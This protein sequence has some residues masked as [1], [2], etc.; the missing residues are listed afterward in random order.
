MTNA[1]HRLIVC[2]EDDKDD[3]FLFEDTLAQVKKGELYTLVFA[4]N[5]E[6][7][8]QTLENLPRLPDILFLDLNMPRKDGFE[9][10]RQLRAS[11]RYDQ[12]PVV[13]LTTTGHRSVIDEAYR[14]GADL[15]AQKP[16]RFEDYRSILIICLCK[17]MDASRT[18]SRESF[19]VKA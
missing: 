4:D 14:L 3:Q 2:G 13:M 7:L 11:P 15:Y 9:C 5:G 10:L 8:M 18:R 1:A 17:A 6:E 19:V 16:S 12:L